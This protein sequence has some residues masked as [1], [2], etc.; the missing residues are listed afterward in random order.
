MFYLAFALLR[1]P[2]PEKA[3]IGPA[4]KQEG[5]MIPQT[6]RLKACMSGCHIFLLLVCQTDMFTSVSTKISQS[7]VV[8][9]R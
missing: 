6:P 7:A 1:Y 9:M 4:E 2:F 8:Q 3:S 5:K